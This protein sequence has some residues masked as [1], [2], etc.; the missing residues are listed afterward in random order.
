MKK[1]LLN[2]LFVLLLL[3]ASS[4]SYAQLP[5]GTLAPDFTLTDL[6]GNSHTLSNYLSSGVPVILEFSAVWCGPCWSYTQSGE[7][8]SL[9]ANHGFSATGDSTVMILFIES[10]LGTLD[11]L[12]GGVGSQG[13]WTSLITFPIIQAPATLAPTYD[14]AYFPTIYTVCQDGTLSETGQLDEAGHLLY[15]NDNCCPMVGINNASVRA[16]DA[17]AYCQ[18]YAADFK[19][20]NLGS[21]P[22]TSAEIE[23]SVNGSL[24]ETINWTGN[25]L[26]FQGE[27]LNTSAFPFTGNL[28]T[29]FEITSVNGTTDDDLS[30]NI[31]IVDLVPAPET[32]SQIVIMELFTDDWPEELYWSITD[33]L[34]I[35]YAE[36]AGATGIYDDLTFYTETIVLPA[37]G[38]YIFHVT[39]SFGDGFDIGSFISLSDEFGDII[40]NVEGDFSE[41]IYPFYID[42]TGFDMSVYPFLDIDADDLY[43]DGIDVILQNQFFTNAQALTYYLELS[44]IGH[45]FTDYA[46]T[47]DITYNSDGTWISNPTSSTVVVSAGQQ[48]YDLF[49]ELEAGTI[50][51]DVLIDI[52]S[53]INR[54]FWEVPFW[55]TITNE[56]TSLESGV[57]EIVLPDSVSYVSSVPPADSIVGNILYY[58]YIDLLPTYSETF[59][60]ILQMPGVDMMGDDIV[61][62]GNT[63]EDSDTLTNELLC[64]YDP[65][66]KLVEPSGV[67]E[68]AFTAFTDSIL[69]YTVRFQNTGTDTAFNIVVSDTL[70]DLLDISSFKFISSS[71][72][73]QTSIDPSSRVANFS[74]ENILLPDSGVNQVAS[75]GFVKFEIEIE[76]GMAEGTPIQNT[77]G[78]YFDFNPAIITNTTLNTFMT[79]PFPTTSIEEILEP[80]FNIYPNPAI[81]IVR[82]E[83][84]F[85]YS[86]IEVFSITG[87][88]L[89]YKN[90]DLS[91]FNVADFANGTYVVKFSDGNSSYIKRIIVLK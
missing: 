42:Q 73:C 12:Q 3:S 15:I 26:T 22:L 87:T 20:K 29:Q 28:N 46:G 25:L 61:I 68:E 11:Q 88:R 91:S 60:L 38:C 67:G 45:F 14:I 4:I 86:K 2:S 90:D 53:G 18:D 82:V 81:D 41:L 89:L 24:V 17:D 40:Y 80:A 71:H 23:Y 48:E 31:D 21:D 50:H 10:D 77:A 72:S 84:D 13:D 39:D 55:V 5:D 35:I 9:W 36:G 56:N 76:N 27:D 69:T 16:L 66:D 75:N 65:N 52:T 7:L 58:S 49:F 6:D 83:S 1:S 8:E 30:N 47:Y 43:T 19:I 74:F 62:I 79:P 32:Y 34:G 78:I 44:G 51:G 85:N 57:F 70:S 37:G 33:E 64:S 59:D 63:E 54:C